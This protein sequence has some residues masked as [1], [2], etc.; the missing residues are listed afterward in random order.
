MDFKWIQNKFRGNCEGEF[1]RVEKR[2][3]ARIQESIQLKLDSTCTGSF[4]CVSMDNEGLVQLLYKADDFLNMNH[5]DFN[6]H[7]I[8]LMNSLF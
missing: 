5:F 7:F 3:R 2:L 8:S 1:K 4:L 6:M